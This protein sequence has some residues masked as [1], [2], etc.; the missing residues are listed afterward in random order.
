MNKRRTMLAA[1][2]GA[3]SLS[4][5]WQR[6]V[7]SS[8]VLP[9]HARSSSRE[10]VLTDV[11][12]EGTYPGEQLA[13]GPFFSQQNLFGVQFSN[14]PAELV[15]T[16]TEIIYTVDGEESRFLHGLNTLKE[17]STF[18]FRSPESSSIA[19]R[20]SQTLISPAH[21]LDQD[22]SQVVIRARILSPTL[23]ENR[24]ITIDSDVVS[25]LER[26]VIELSFSARGTVL[27]PTVTIQDGATVVLGDLVVETSRSST[28][29]VSS[30]PDLLDIPY[31]GALF[32]SGDKSVKRSELCIFITP[33]IVDPN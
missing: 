13:A 23:V 8:V 14:Q 24:N 33:E 5:V 31:V 17:D 29:E 10:I 15:I 20:L 19:G 28:I 16:S 30:V 12:V 7:V 2:T 32:R 6:P 18:S 9:A 22:V 3:T 26:S 1:L 4:A 25:A 27:C 11:L 21:A